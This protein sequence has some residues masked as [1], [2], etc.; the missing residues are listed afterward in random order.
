MRAYRVL[1]I[2]RKE[3]IQILRDR[4]SLAIVVLMP[5]T[6]MLLFGY[7]VNLDTSAIPLYVFDREGSQQSRNLVEHFQSS[8]YFDVVN[9]VDN[10]P[11][12]LRAIDEGRCRMGIVIPP[13]FS[14]KLNAGHSVG[15]QALVDAIDDN[16]AN[17]AFSYSDIVIRGFSAD[18]QLDWEH[19][20]GLAGFQYP[21]NVESR[22]WFN[23]QLE[24]RAFIVP[25][26]VALVMTVIGTFLT[27]LT[28]AREWERGTME[29]LI[30]TPVQPSEIM[31]GKLVPYFLISVIDST[32]C[33]AI[34]V[35]GFRVPFRGS[36]GTLMVSS[37]LFLVVVLAMGYLIS[38]IA[39]TQLVASHIA[40][41]TGFLPAFLLSG[42][43]YPIDGM[44][45]VLRVFTHIIPARYYVS[46][47]KGV[48]LKGSSISLLRGDLLS[49][50]GFGIVVG[51]LATRALQ[52]RLD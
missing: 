9:S 25:G 51:T 26:V 43:I 47:L 5:V 33:V 39:K 34:A 2:A 48:F 40:L 18:V 21:L 12:L 37:A 27:S 44:P 22:V 7:G 36:Y 3:F 52:K 35:W 30:S 10:Y 11:A 45:A 1:A 16:T 14:R 28:I 31:V 17:L 41:L 49:L 50:V 38:V 20:Q 8:R 15:V 24:S 13:D 32:L 23:E 42:F 29:Q 46:I 4:R 6:L 19:R